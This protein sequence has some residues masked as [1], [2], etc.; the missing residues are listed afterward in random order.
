MSLRPAVACALSR[1]TRERLAAACLCGISRAPSGS[2]LTDL[3]ARLHR[4]HVFH[5]FHCSPSALTSPP[6]PQPPVQK[7]ETHKA[8]GRE[9][10]E[11][12]FGLAKWGEKGDTSE[13]TPGQNLASDTQGCELWGRKAQETRRLKATISLSV[14]TIPIKYLH[15]SWL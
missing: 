5:S 1:G 13:H 7:Q 4:L 6:V 11:G 14:F 2:R 8:G 9:A 3:C 12:G 10:T 15:S